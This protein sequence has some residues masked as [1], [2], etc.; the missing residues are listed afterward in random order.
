M[1]LKHYSSGWEKHNPKI[2]YHPKNNSNN[3]NHS[4]N[5]N[6][7]TIRLLYNT[8]IDYGKKHHNNKIMRLEFDRF[9]TFMIK[10]NNKE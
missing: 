10:Y 8:I 1:E 3:S 4:T 5:I 7:D 2:F 6:H 9:K